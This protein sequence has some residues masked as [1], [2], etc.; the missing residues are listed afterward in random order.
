MN[1][2]DTLT[3]PVSD[4][5]NALVMPFKA[6]FVVALCGLI[7]WM[8]YTGQWWVKWVALG[9]AI[10]TLVA[11]ARGLRGLLLIGLVAWVGRWVYRRYGASAREQFDDWVHSTKPR[12]GQVVQAWS[13][14]AT[15][16][17]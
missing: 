16:S 10:A 11:L 3:R 12:I 4:V 7:N 17:R 6:L 13:G 2:I 8:T 9:M 15:S 14:R 5:V 1:P